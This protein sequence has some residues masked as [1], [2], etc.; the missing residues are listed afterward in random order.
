MHRQDA[1]DAKR[2]V[3]ASRPAATLGDL[4]VLAVRKGALARRGGGRFGR[5][6]TPAHQAAFLRLW[7]PQ[8]RL[9][10][11]FANRVNRGDEIGKINDLT[12][13]NAPPQ[14]LR[15]GYRAQPDARRARH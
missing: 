7:H 6:L 4:G 11:P 1:K 14:A 5:T 9:H 3:E 10:Y 15:Q 2:R 12:K 8:G 13:A